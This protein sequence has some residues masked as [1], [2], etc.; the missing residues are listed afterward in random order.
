MCQISKIV[1]FAFEREENIVGEGENT[2]TGYKPFFSFPNNVLKGF[3][4]MVCVENQVCLGF[5]PVSTVF[6]LFNSNIS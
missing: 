6:Q 5:Y 4:H 3:C 1:G 2:C